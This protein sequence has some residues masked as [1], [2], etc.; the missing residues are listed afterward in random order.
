MTCCGRSLG[1]S[2]SD[3]A[4]VT[5]ALSDE[6]N[7]LPSP[8]EVSTRPGRGHRPRSAQRYMSLSFV[9]VSDHSGP[10]DA[11]PYIDCNGEPIDLRIGFAGE[12][13]C[14]GRLRLRHQHPTASTM[15]RLIDRLRRQAEREAELA[16]DASIR[17]GVR[18]FVRLH[19]ASILELKR[20]VG[21]WGTLAKV[22]KKEGLKWKSG[23]P[24]TGDHLRALVS[25]IRSSDRRR[26][27]QSA[28]APR[29]HPRDVAQLTSSGEADQPQERPSF[30]ARATRNPRGLAA[31]IDT[32]SE[33]DGDVFDNGWRKT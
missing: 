33:P 27:D 25:E 9:Y 21:T 14:A 22:L 28:R 2:A 30:P 6:A 26:S 12:N 13:Y 17:R 7:R 29:V 1:K 3:I 10:Q 11:T 23:K 15:S 31:L 5:G 19:L 8:N 4:S 24:V 20:V 16:R 18:T 32:T